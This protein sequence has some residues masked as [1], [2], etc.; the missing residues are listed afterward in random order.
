MIY[1]NI[2]L[3]GIM[4]FFQYLGQESP[5]K[6]QS[7]NKLLLFFSRSQYW[8]IFRPCKGSSESVLLLGK[9]FE[10]L[11]VIF[12]RSKNCIKNEVFY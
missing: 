9:G 4:F 7:T 5:S 2:L 8:P 3:K 12:A 11:A 10:S 6:S 1:T